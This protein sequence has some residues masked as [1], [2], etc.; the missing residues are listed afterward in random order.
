MTTEF[1]HPT[2]ENPDSLFAFADATSEFE[3]LAEA[4]DVCCVRALE[5]DQQCVAQRVAVEA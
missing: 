4:G 3:P 5:G 1:L 2:G